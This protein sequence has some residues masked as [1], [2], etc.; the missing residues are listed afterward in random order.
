MGRLDWDGADQGEP[1]PRMGANGT[2]GNQGGP[3]REQ[4]GGAQGLTSRSADSSQVRVAAAQ[5]AREEWGTRGE[6]WA[7]AIRMPASQPSAVSEHGGSA[8]KGA[9]DSAGGVEIRLSASARVRRGPQW[10]RAVA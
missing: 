10:G 1:A 2:F 5:R 8:R 6:G 7:E 9:G 4:G 3:D